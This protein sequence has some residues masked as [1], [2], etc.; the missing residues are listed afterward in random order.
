MGLI[1]IS[2]WLIRRVRSDPDYAVDREISA[3]SL[4]AVM[5]NRGASAA[6]GLAWGP[7][8]N[9]C[10]FPLFIGRRVT[11]RNPRHL[12]VGKSVVIDDGVVIEALSRTGVSIG[13]GTT[14]E[15][16]VMIRVTG[17]L[18]NLGEGFTIGSRC[19][20]GA[21]SYIGASGG[22]SIGDNVLIGQRV[23]MHSENHVFSDPRRPIRDQGDT[24]QGI[25]IG[26]DCWIG[27][28]AIILDGVTIGSGS[29][30]GAGSLVNENIPPGSVAVGV[31]AKTV[32][33]RGE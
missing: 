2:D 33:K 16:Q 31:P 5:A 11:I 21:F 15:K 20:I 22:I 25:V 24:R 26:D 18:R 1:K 32:K 3:V 4:A 12:R 28:G 27:S 23:S 10:S 7:L 14:L 8:L 30:I 6:R 9:R 13:D 19:S 29:V 17:V